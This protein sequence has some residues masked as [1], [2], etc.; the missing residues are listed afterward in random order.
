V[1]KIFNHYFHQRT[2]LHIVFDLGFLVAAVMILTLVQVADP[3]SVVSTVVT[4]ALLFASGMLLINGALGF[5]QRI[6]T[7][8]VSQ[9]AA[10]AAMSFCLSIPLSFVI[11]R[12][13]P[14]QVGDE[15]VLA[16]MLIGAIALMLLNRVRVNH[17]M[18][19]DLQRQRVLVFG[20]GATAK[21]VGRSLKKSDA[22]VDLVGYYASP[23]E[24]SPE[25]SAWGLLSP[26]KSLTDIVNEQQVDEIVVAVSE[27]RGGSMPLRELLD[28]KL[29]GVCGSSISPH[30][31]KKR[32]DR[33]DSIPCTLGGLFLAMVLARVWC[34]PL[35]NAC[36]TL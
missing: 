34:A 33:Y 21:I 25:V 11:F 9:T 22:S 7:R 1:I 24:A 29:Q 10:R 30:T 5:Y 32:W 17:A 6:H 35:S 14:V 3:T 23:N 20:T 36:L 2:L 13:S 15:K 28:C 26:D 27:R 16:L 8:T 18:P 12:L 4:K 19:K 31:S